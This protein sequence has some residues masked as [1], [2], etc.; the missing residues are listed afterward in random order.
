MPEA[1]TTVID[2][3]F[4]LISR[5]RKASFSPGLT[6]CID[7]GWPVPSMSK[8][9]PNRSGSDRHRRDPAPTGRDRGNPGTH[10]NRSRRACP[11]AGALQSHSSVVPGVEPIARLHSDVVPRAGLACSCTAALSPESNAPCK[12]A[13]ALSPESNAL[14]K[15]IAVS[16][17]ELSVPCKCTAAS[18]PEPSAP[19]RCTAALSPESNALCERATVY[20]VF[21]TLCH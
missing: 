16:S 1:L 19:C 15:W 17:P 4:L 7:C 11:D 14:C 8:E 9:T 18:S 2:D 13:A 6:H 10:P 5:T 12:T 21:C 20:D 3:P